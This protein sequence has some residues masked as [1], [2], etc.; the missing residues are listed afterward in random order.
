MSSHY[1]FCLS[2]IAGG[3]CRRGLALLTPASMLPLHAQTAP[4][5]AA[6][7]AALSDSA[8]AGPTRPS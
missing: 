7:Q 8:K 1:P 6:Q 2:D 5:Q 4:Q 3:L